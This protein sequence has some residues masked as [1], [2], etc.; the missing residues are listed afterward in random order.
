MIRDCEQQH[1][2]ENLPIVEQ[3]RDHG[4]DEGTKKRH[5]QCDQDGQAVCPINPSRYSRTIRPEAQQDDGQL[6]A[7]G[8]AQEDGHSAAFL[9]CMSSQTSRYR[10]G[11]NGN[12]VFGDTPASSRWHPQK[13]LTR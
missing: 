7:K 2:S 3:T 8:D 5:D 12:R 4:H 13:T 1:F 9:L 6:Q 10:A 11:C